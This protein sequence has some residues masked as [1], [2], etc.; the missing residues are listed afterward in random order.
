M[1]NVDL[2]MIISYLY[3]YTRLIMVNTK[4]QQLVMALRK[5]HATKQTGKIAPVNVAHY[6]DFKRK[7]AAQA[8]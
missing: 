3:Y 5:S 8:K 1:R 2:K 4:K 7:H 6:L